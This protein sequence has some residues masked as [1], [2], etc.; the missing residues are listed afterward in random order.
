[1]VYWSIAARRTAATTTRES[2]QSRRVHELLLNT[3]LLL[4]FIPVPGL[5]RRILPDARWVVPLGLAV[6]VAF[7]LLAISARRHLGKFWSAEITQKAGH[8]LV[9]T[10]PYRLV[11]HPIYTAMLGMVLGMAIVSGDLHAFVG[12]A[13]LVFAYSR[14]IQLEEANLRD[15]FGETYEDYRRSTRALIPWII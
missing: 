9:Q 5:D 1:M 10:G 7:F 15:M 3:G 11:R 6:Q 8:Q 4:V 14:K 2:R 13:L 12:M